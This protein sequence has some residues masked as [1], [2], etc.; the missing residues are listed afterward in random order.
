MLV[1]LDHRSPVLET[2][3]DL[4]AESTAGKTG[5]AERD[6]GEPYHRLLKRAKTM[7]G[8][9]L[10]LANSDLTAAERAGAVEVER[11]RRSRDPERVR[12]SLAKEAALFSMLGRISPTEQRHAWAKI[13]E[14]SA[15]LTVSE[16][17]QNSWNQLCLRR[18]QEA[19]IGK[20]V[21]PFRWAYP[22]RAEAQ[23]RI[24]AG[25]LSW[26]RPCFVRT[27]SAQL[28][29]SS[30]F[31]E[32]C[33]ATIESLL[34]E[35]TD[36]RVRSLLDLKIEPNPT[37]VRFHG[38]IRLRL[39]GNVK[40]YVGLDG[41]SALSEI[42]LSAAESIE[43]RAPR[44]VSIENATTF[45]ELCRLG[46]E[47]LLVFTSYA[48]QATINFIKRLPS[49]TPLFHWGD[50]DPWGFD[51]LRDLRKKTGRAIT[52]LNM[53]FGRWAEALPAETRA[54]RILTPL[55][56]ERL[57]FLLANEAMADVREELQTMST[58]GTTGDFEQEGLRLLSDVFPYITR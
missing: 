33:L 53:S 54:R 13:F 17:H 18:G 9:A 50:S 1:R 35:A 37:K 28:A 22:R 4:Y 46:C 26:N 23:L 10:S 52:P 24:V 2:L 30:K 29:G 31:I 15:K 32:Q 45:H 7:S 20:G 44:C 38:A 41:E 3:A 21:A 42:D 19:L 14:N 34:S 58:M 56:R 27:A 43:V 25:L 48:N 51:V 49:K 40:D 11:N 47:D 12:V 16:A 57:A 36:G 5:I 55:D 6:F 39:R 8:A